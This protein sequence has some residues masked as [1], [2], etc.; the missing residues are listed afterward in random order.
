[1]LQLKTRLG[2]L[3]GESMDG[4]DAEFREIMWSVLHSWANGCEQVVHSD[5]WQN[6]SFNVLLGVT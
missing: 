2:F 4:C 1:M 6:T 3:K 5:A